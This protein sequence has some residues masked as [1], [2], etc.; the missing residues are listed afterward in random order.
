MLASKTEL[1]SRKELKTREKMQLESLEWI[2]MEINKRVAARLGQS[3]LISCSLENKA[4]KQK[5]AGT[6]S[7]AL[8][9]RKPGR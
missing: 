2:H 4:A 3:R 9:R 7:V 8:I 1:T 5:G 6:R